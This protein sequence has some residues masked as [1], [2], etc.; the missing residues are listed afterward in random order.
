MKILTL[1]QR[2]SEALLA[3]VII[4]RSTSLLLLKL[5]LA[6]MEA[7]TLMSLRFTT[8][9]L[10]LLTLFRRRIRCGRKLLGKSICH[11]IRR[12]FQPAA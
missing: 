10:I 3:A 6:D 4:A 11:R 12:L 5:G 7:F 9:G 2:G 8:A 1:T